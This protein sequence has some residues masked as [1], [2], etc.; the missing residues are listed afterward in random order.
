M[1]ALDGAGDFDANLEITAPIATLAVID[2]LLLM[3]PGGEPLP[4]LVLALDT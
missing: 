3:R 4:F 2:I 1:Q